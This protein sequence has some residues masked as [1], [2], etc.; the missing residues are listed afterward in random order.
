MR[1]YIKNGIQICEP[2]YGGHT[3]LKLNYVQEKGSRLRRTTNMNVRQRV[4]EARL[5]E[6]ISKNPNLARELGIEIRYKQNADSCRQHKEKR[7][8]GNV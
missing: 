4:L 6:R 1:N 3:F 8:T 5:A 2:E 7:S